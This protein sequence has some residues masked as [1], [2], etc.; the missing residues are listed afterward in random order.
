MKPM[1]AGIYVNRGTRH[2]SRLRRMTRAGVSVVE[3]ALLVQINL[4]HPARFAEYDAGFAACIEAFDYPRVAIG[5][6]QL[7]IGSCKLHVFAFREDLPAVL[8]H[9]YGRSSAGWIVRQFAPIRR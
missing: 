8:E 1:V 2:R 5:Y 3:M 9:R 4:H 7:F 6:A